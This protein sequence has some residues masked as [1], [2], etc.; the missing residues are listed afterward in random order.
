MAL[1]KL[2]DIQLAA[3]ESAERYP[4]ARKSAIELVTDGVAL[5]DATFTRIKSI[6]AQIVTTEA[7]VDARF[8][9][10]DV[11]AT[12]Q[13][14]ERIALLKL[15]DSLVDSNAKLVKRISFSD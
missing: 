3:D 13:D 10:D 1:A 2:A 4:L 15:K 12:T 7:A 14:A 6:D 8:D 9:E 11:L 5:L